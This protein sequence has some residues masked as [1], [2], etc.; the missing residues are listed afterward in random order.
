MSTIDDLLAQSLLLPC[1]HAPS[2]VVPYEDGA[3]DDLLL[4]DSY[5]HDTGDDSAAQSLA[6]LCEAVVTYCFADQLS[7]FLTDQIPQPHTA[8]ILG[9]VLYLAGID[10]GA[11]FWWQYAAGAED[12]PASYCL[13]LH[14]LAHGEPHAAAL[15]QAQA[16]SYAPPADDDTNAED[17]PALHAMT[18]DTSLTTVLRI[19]SHLTRTA[20]PRHSPAARAVIEFVASAVAGGYTRHPDLEMPLPGDY[21]AEKLE[22]VIASASGISQ[23]S[24]PTRQTTVDTP[25]G[26]ST[27]LPS[28]LAADSTRK[29]PTAATPAGPDQ[30]LVEVT[31]PPIGHEPAPAHTLHTFFERAAAVCWKTAT[32]TGSDLRG[33]RL[34]YHLR[35]WVPRYTP[36]PSGFGRPRTPSSSGTAPTSF[37]G[38]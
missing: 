36:A 10:T 34:A 30:L 38:R 21:F 35:R 13:Y 7:D 4:W 3:D 1:S 5:G 28:R 17:A 27:D 23:P 9:C 11:R 31:A 18:P 14:H 29:I 15:W 26:T 2:D 24:R 20:P 12:T 16:G 25:S 8:R 37:H 6:A 33:D 22:I 32:A 19:L